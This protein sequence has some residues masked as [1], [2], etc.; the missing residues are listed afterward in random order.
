MVASIGL[1]K[2]IEIHSL[3]KEMELNCEKV[4][5]L[6]VGE[7]DYDPPIEVIQATCDAATHGYTKYTSV[8]GDLNLRKCI[9]QDLTKRK[10]TNYGPENIVVS[11]GAKQAVL[12]ALMAVV[13]P[14]DEVLIPSPYWT[15][16]PEMVKLVGGVPRIIPTLPSENYELTAVSL[17]NALATYPRASC[18]ILCNPSNP[19]GSVMS[20]ASMHSLADVLAAYAHV[21]VVSDE[22]YERLTYGTPHV[23]FA[24][25]PAMFHRTI[26]INGFSKSHSMT[27][28]RLGYSASSVAVAKA[29]SKLQSQITSCASSLS[30]RAGVAALQEVPDSWLADKVQQLKHKRDVAHNLLLQIPHVSCPLPDGAFYLLADVSAYYGMVTVHGVEIASAHTFCLELL[31]ER[32]VSG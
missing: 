14:G 10:L 1:S 3:T 11:N 18:I 25:I 9:A 2:T 4:F 16:Y 30:Q 31:R 8:N 28:Y 20:E 7:P 5:S 12:Q 26:V 27:G 6:C 19:T 15:S 17:A 22:I 13:S 29:I 21:A 32:Q 24:S 23:S